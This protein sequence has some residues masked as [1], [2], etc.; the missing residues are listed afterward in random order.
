M[1]LLFLS[2]IHTASADTYYSTTGVGLGVGFT[3]GTDTALCT[4]WM[5]DGVKPREC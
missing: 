2:H 1:P 5:K 3:D 4:T